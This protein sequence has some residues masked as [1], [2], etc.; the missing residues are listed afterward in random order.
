MQKEWRKEI[1]LTQPK[2]QE[3]SPCNQV[4]HKKSNATGSTAPSLRGTYERRIIHKGGLSSW[5]LPSQARR[6]VRMGRGDMHGWCKGLLWPHR[7]C[8]LQQTSLGIDHTLKG[9]KALSNLTI[10]TSTPTSWQSCD[11][12]RAKKPSQYAVQAL[13]ATN[14]N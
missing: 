8:L 7:P 3:R 12:H 5:E 10:R 11:S 4:A 2:L 9:N 13:V 1:S 6:S 14:H